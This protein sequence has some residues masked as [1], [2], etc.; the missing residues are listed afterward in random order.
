M[1]NAIDSDDRM[2]SKDEIELVEGLLEIEE[3]LSVF[4][5]PEVTISYDYME[6]V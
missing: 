2:N 3:P 1:G 5:E 4:F 6:E